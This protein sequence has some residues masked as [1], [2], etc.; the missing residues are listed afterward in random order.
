MSQN[1]ILMKKILL[2][3]SLPTCQKLMKNCTHYACTQ[4]V[5]C[6]LLLPERAGGG[7][8]HDL[9]NV[10][11]VHMHSCSEVGLGVPESIICKDTDS[12]SSVSHSKRQ[13]AAK[14]SLTS[15][16]I[17][18]C[19]YTLYSMGPMHQMTSKGLGEKYNIIHDS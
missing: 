4:Y 11:L 19:R 5:S 16:T 13:L 3:L 1:Y 18:E 15:P 17:L 7:G 8:V 2:P 14:H 10:L 9:K 6:S 12:L